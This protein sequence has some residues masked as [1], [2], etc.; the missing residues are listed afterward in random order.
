MEKFQIISLHLGN[1][2]VPATDHLSLAN[3]ELE[4]LA[5]GPRRIEDGAVV[6]GAGVVDHSGLAGLGEGDA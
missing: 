4:R 6:Q 5:A 3:G 1:S 2:L